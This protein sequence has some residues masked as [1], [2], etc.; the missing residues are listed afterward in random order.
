MRKLDIYRASAEDGGWFALID[1]EAGE[2]FIGYQERDIGFTIVR[3]RAEKPSL[4]DLQIKCYKE[5]FQKSNWLTWLVVSKLTKQQ[6]YDLLVRQDGV[7]IG[8]III[9]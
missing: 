3:R 9:P 5:T 6:T 4:F 1:E 7:R 2:Q 8:S